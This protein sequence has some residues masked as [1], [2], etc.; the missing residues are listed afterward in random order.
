[1]ADLTEQE[2]QTLQKPIKQITYNDHRVLISARD[3]FLAPGEL[4]QR[5]TAQYKLAYALERS[6]LPHDEK[7]QHWE[8]AASLAES[9]SIPCS[10]LYAHAADHMERDGAASRAAI[11]F[12]KAGEFAINENQKV[13]AIRAYLRSGRNMY[14]QSGNSE[15]ASEL[16]RKENDLILENSSGVS[17]L[18]LGIFKAIS[19]YGESPLRV[20]IVALLVII[21]NSLVYTFAG[22]QSNISGQEIYSFPTSV[23]F[24][25]VTFTTL[26]Y[27]DY[28]PI[29]SLTRA[30]ASIEAICGLFLMSLF[31]VTLVRRYGRA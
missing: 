12:E 6:R 31:L 19:D 2:V 3:K 21:A 24:S 7:A 16:F 5:F 11:L 18:S 13:S 15:K 29:G 9:Q 14:V 27:G 4:P 10:E 25:I 28:S 22:I 1:M 26:G 23:Y 20:G 30:V 8:A 17:K